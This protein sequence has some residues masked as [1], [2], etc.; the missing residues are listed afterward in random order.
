MEI[1]DFISSGSGEGSGEGE[2]CTGQ[3][4]SPSI[5]TTGTLSCSETREGEKGER[6]VV[7]VSV[8]YAT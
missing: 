2:G 5:I 1:A 4:G 7:S 6:I 8:C 3:L